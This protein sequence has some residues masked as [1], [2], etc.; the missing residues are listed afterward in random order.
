METRL[1]VHKLIGAIFIINKGVGLLVHLLPL[2]IDAL[3]YLPL[4]SAIGEF[5]E[6]DF[7]FHVAPLC[8]QFDFVEC[9]STKVF[10]LANDHRIFVDIGNVRHD[11]DTNRC[12]A[13]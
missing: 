10:Y 13:Q 7:V 4:P 5:V 11:A 9:D 6:S 1:C 2:A 12:D 8:D 3:P